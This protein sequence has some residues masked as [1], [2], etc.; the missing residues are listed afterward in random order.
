MLWKPQH[1]S[2]TI[3]KR[4]DVSAE[5]DGKIV[6][7]ILVQA[8]HYKGFFETYFKQNRKLLGQQQLLCTSVT[9]QDILIT[10]GLDS[11]MC[12]LYILYNW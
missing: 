8:A 11:C 6:S 10:N 4:G 9:C 7:I 5:L 2:S 12:T 1:K 3:S